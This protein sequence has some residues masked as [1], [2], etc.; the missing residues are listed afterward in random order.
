ME[1]LFD[2]K[3]EWNTDACYSMNESWKHYAKC[4][5]PHTKG[6]LG[7]GLRNDGLMD[8]WLLFNDENGKYSGSRY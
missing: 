5:K 6:H 2:H 4:K 1:Y 7:G 3:K 8:M